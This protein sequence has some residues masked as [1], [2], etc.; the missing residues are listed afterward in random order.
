MIRLYN[1]DH[2]PYCKRVREKLAELNLEY[3]RI[4]VPKSKEER[5]E[6]VRVSGQSSVPVLVDG[7]VVI[8]DDDDRII[9]HLEGKYG[10]RV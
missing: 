8:A 3:E 5:S 10:T 6:V 2:C 7:N 1:L 4:D 9:E